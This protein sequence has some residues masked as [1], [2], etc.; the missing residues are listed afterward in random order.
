MDPLDDLDRG[1]PP[2]GKLGTLGTLGTL[3]R[4]PQIPKKLP[5]ISLPLAQPKSGV[6]SGLATHKAQIFD[7]VT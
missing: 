4:Q 3:A 2:L 7:R 6:V 5:A 1:F